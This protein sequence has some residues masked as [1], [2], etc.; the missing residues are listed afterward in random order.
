MSGPHLSVFVFFDFLIFF[1]DLNIC[2]KNSYL[3]LGV[4]KLSEP[5]FFDS[6]GSVLFD[7]N[8]KPTIW[9]I[10]SRIIKLR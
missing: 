6:S 1:T 7:K 4:S 8:I 9:S 2:F 5:I 10:F 3:E